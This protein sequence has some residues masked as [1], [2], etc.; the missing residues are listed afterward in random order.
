MIKRSKLPRGDSGWA[1][2]GHLPALF[3]DGIIDMLLKEHGQNA[4]CTI[5]V[6]MMPTVIFFDDEDVAWIQTQER[7]GQTVTVPLQITHVTILLGI[8]TIIF[9]AGSHHKNAGACL[10]TSS[11]EELH[12]A[13]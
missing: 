12:S 2:F 13:N 9:S 5:N 10:P 6:L 7:K 3:G 4:M 11:S 1:V 8:D